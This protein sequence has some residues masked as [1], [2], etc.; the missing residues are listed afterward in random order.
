[1]FF[2]LMFPFLPYTALNMHNNNNTNNNTNNNNN[3]LL[4][5]LNYFIRI[6]SRKVVG[7]YFL[8]LFISPH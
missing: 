7:V 2:I 4:L 8:S 1:M 5:L 3:V 6:L